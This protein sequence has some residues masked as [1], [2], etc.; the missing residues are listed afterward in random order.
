MNNITKDDVIFFLD[1]VGYSLQ[2]ESVAKLYNKKPY[3]KLLSQRDSVKYKRFIAIY[4]V[5]NHVLPE[6][7]QQI[8][9]ELY[10]VYKEKTPLKIVADLLNIS[11]ERVR[12]LRNEAETRMAKEL[13]NILLEK[14]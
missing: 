4:T 7:E 6:R 9:N 14:N 1:M 13:L 2:P 10:G 11:T 3:T 8:L 12:Q 5:I